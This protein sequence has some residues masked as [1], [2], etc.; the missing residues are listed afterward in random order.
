MATLQRDCTTQPGVFLACSMSLDTA[1]HAVLWTQHATAHIPCLAVVHL[2]RV[3]TAALSDRAGGEFSIQVPTHRTAAGFAPLRVSRAGLRTAE[4]GKAGAQH[5]PRFPTPTAPPSRPATTPPPAA[6][7]AAPVAAAFNTTACAAA[8]IITAARA[9]VV[10]RGAISRRAKN[11]GGIHSHFSPPLHPTHSERHA[12][13]HGRGA[14]V[15]HAAIQDG[16]RLCTQRFATA[17]AALCASASTALHCTA[18]HSTRRSRPH[19]SL[20]P[21]RMPLH[22]ARAGV[23]H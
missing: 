18:Q 3:S 2:A 10:A 8:A 12:G 9:L 17:S 19:P 20:P 14:A 13:R 6:V 5:A 15:I 11:Q 23:C 16:L 4:Q 7:S 1:S 22:L 21:H